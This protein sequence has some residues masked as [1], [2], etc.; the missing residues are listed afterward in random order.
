MPF[1]ITHFYAGG[2]ADQYAVVL[3]AV[4]PGGNLPAG[5]I[6]SAAGPCDGGWIISAVWE[7]RQ[8]FET[9]V[10]DRLMSALSG[11]EGGFDN[12]PEEHLAEL[13]IYQTA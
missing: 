3:D 10:V 8:A 12:A 1:L 4:H 13:T 5:Q 6:S 7:S 2:T 9:F 11:L